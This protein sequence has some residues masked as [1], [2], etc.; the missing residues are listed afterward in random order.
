MKDE[1]MLSVMFAD[2]VNFRE[3][4]LRQ[5]LRHVSRQRRI[6]Q[7][8][9]AL[10][11]LAMA[12]VTVWWLLPHGAAL[13]SAPHL[14]IVRTKALSAEQLVTTRQ[15][16]VTII[17]SDKSSLALVGD[18][19]LLELVPGETKLLVWHAPHQAE[20]VIFGP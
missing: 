8:R 12:A 7:A 14:N 19:Q 6:R 13:K 4:S 16:S 17:S 1:Q 20:L 10:L 11:T 9:R 5:T 2:V 15:N 18:D 3:Q